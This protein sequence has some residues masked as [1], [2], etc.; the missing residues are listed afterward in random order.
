L[1]EEDEG[2]FRIKRTFCLYNLL[3]RATD[4][5]CGSTGTLRSGPRYGAAEGIVDLEGARPVAESL[6]LLDVARSQL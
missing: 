3:E 5:D 6:E 2:P 1:S 4:V